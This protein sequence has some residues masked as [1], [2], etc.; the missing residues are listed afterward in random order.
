M[1]QER[2]YKKPAKVGKNHCPLAYELT[3]NLS[4]HGDFWVDDSLKG[5]ANVGPMVFLVFL[6]CQQRYDPDWIYG[7]MADKLATEKGF[8]QRCGFSH[9]QPYG[10]DWRVE[11]TDK[12]VNRSN[13]L[14]AVNREGIHHQA[15]IIVQN[16][17]EFLQ[18]S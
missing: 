12:G 9:A 6:L 15:R 2:L 13:W 14:C 5:G 3:G 11:P 1:E 10:T 17:L 18:R 7:R 8:V 4:Y 16:G